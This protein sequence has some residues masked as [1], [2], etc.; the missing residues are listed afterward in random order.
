[1]RSVSRR[2]FMAAPPARGSGLFHSPSGRS[3]RRKRNQVK[4]QA[5]LT[6]YDVTTSKV[7]PWS[8]NTR[9]P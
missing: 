8:R 5:P 7:R 1:M 3:G 4:A 6:R 2:G 9:R